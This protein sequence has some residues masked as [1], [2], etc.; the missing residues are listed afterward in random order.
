M[1]RRCLETRS[2]KGNHAGNV[3]GEIGEGTHLEQSFLQA[4]MVGICTMLMASPPR[5]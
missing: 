1:N 5:Y 3:Q 2:A 4:A